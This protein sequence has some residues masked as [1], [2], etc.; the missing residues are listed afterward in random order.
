MLTVCMLHLLLPD[1]AAEMHPNIQVVGM[2][3]LFTYR[4]PEGVV[5]CAQMDH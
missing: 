5:R 1:A 4:T 3:M 2:C